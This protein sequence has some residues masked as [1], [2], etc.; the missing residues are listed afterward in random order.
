MDWLSEL[1]DLVFPLFEQFIII[2]I[3]LGFV[4]IFFLPGF[5]WSLV[6]L[7]QLRI[8]ERLIISV[9]LSIVV[10]T[11]S[12]LFANRLFGV[13]I[14]GINSVLIIGTVSVLPLVVYCFNRYRQRRKDSATQNS[15]GV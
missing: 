15:T 8:I 9:A 12:I 11:I 6:L 14:T 5:T 13:P 7:K 1:L 3:I 4:L 10:V 2:R